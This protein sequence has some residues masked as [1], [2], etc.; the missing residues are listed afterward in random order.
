MMNRLMFVAVLLTFGLGSACFAQPFIFGAGQ[1]MNSTLAKWTEI[2]AGNGYTSN[3]DPTG[4]VQVFDSNGTNVTGICIFGINQFN[5]NSELHYWADKNGFN[6]QLSSDGRVQVLDGSGN[7]VSLPVLN[8]VRIIHANHHLNT[9]ATNSGFTTKTGEDGKVH[10]FDSAGK[11]VTNIAPPL[12]GVFMPA[13]VQES[14]TSSSPE[15][16]VDSSE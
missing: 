4:K 10:V 3:M 5:I 8:S 1:D 12:P 13:P 14:Q 16:A 6:T 7:D 11:E 9:W 2:N 15:D